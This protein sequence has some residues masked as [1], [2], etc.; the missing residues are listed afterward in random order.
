M[1]VKILIALALIVLV[2]V[3]II[4][5]QPSTYRVQRSTVI[6]APP[7]TVFA[8]VNDFQK[9]NAWNPWSKVDPEM[10]TTYEGPSSGPGAKY[11]WGGNKDVGEGRMTIAESRPDELIKVNLEFLKPFAANATAEFTFKPVAG[12]TEATW[13][14]Y[15]DKNFMA[16]AIHLV[17]NMDKMLGDQFDKGLADMKAASEAAK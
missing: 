11:S 10:K 14:M 17:M 9:W 6:A 12:G 13:A 15:G 4:A 1:L 2:L 7:A 5:V 3:I 8:Q 16:K